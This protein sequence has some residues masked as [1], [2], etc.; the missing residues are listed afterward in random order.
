MKSHICHE[1]WV[2]G[3][4]KVLSTPTP[5]PTHPAHT[6]P[7]TTSYSRPP[8]IYNLLILINLYIFIRKY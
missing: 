8:Y 2:N 1:Y 6:H 3:K 4:Y 5:T 7:P